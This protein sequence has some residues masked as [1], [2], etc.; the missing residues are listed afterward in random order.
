M[1]PISPTGSRW[2]PEGRGGGGGQLEE[3]ETTGRRKGHTGKTDQIQA[4]KK[5]QR[6]LE[7]KVSGKSA[8]GRRFG[9]VLRRLPS[10]H[11]LSRQRVAGRLLLVCAL[12]AN[13][14]L[15]VENRVTMAGRE[16]AAHLIV[17]GWILIGDGAAC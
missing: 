7:L 14:L 10:H 5:T 9:S 4:V 6:A 11:A 2:S 13:A 16:R 17:N 1:L 12:N 8:G 15:P 3:D